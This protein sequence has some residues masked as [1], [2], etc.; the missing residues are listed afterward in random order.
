[1][2]IKTIVKKYK[3]HIEKELYLTGC[4]S[5]PD[6]L[7]KLSANDA[8]AIYDLSV[9]LQVTNCSEKEWLHYL[10]VAAELG[11]EG[12][13]EQLADFYNY[14]ECDVLPTDKAKALELYSKLADMGNADGLYHMGLYYIDNEGKENKQELGEEYI[15]KAAETNGYFAENVAAYFEWKGDMEKANHYYE[16]ANEYME[17]SCINI[18]DIVSIG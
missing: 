15:Q 16:L 9:I 17:S 5:T 1:M 10:K 3:K 7:L 2:D 6:Y 8:D 11:S 12:A 13:M 18:D 4:D 14:D